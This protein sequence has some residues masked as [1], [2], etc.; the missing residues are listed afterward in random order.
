MNKKGF[1]LAEVIVALAVLSIISATVLGVVMSVNKINLKYDDKLLLGYSVESIV[2]I[3]YN[4]ADETEFLEDV[5][6]CFGEN[7]LAGEDH[8]YTLYYMNGQAATESNYRYTVSISYRA[9]KIII[10][11]VD[12]KNASAIAEREF[13]R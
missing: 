4:T 1:S 9:D 5:E 12:K 2:Q 6:F 7:S 13:L 11:A 10:S 3:Y 8:E